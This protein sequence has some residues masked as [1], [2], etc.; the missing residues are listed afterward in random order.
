MAFRES[1]LW[2]PSVLMDVSVRGNENSCRQS[3][4]APHAALIWLINISSSVWPPKAGLHF[5][6]LNL[7]D[8]LPRAQPPGALMCGEHC[9]SVWS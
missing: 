4:E 7:K 2:Y 8:C 6:L 3:L 9:V 1:S 5:L